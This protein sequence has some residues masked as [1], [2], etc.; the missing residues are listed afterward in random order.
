[1][2]CL[3]HE[4]CPIPTAAAATGSTAAPFTARLLL[5][6][7]QV[8]GQEDN[9]ATPESVDMHLNMLRG[10]V[11]A[12]GGSVEVVGCEQVSC[13]VGGCVMK[14]HCCAVASLLWL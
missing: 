12:Y 11:A 5:S 1:M 3:V 14:V 2:C 4:L 8:G 9:R 6:L 13:W 10:A 7:P